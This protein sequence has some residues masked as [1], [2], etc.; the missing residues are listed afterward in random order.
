M[1]AGKF[2]TGTLSVGDIEGAAFAPICSNGSLSYMAQNSTY[3]PLPASVN[4]FKGR[5]YCQISTSPYY[6][7][8]G[9]DCKIDA[10]VDLYMIPQSDD[11]R[12][13]SQPSWTWITIYNDNKYVNIK[14]CSNSSGRE[15]FVCFEDVSGN[16]FPNRAFLVCQY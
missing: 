1:S 7:C 6:L 4:D 15:G 2:T 5:E 9:K 14:A 16:D 10:N 11:I 3:M 8:V 12:L 13:L